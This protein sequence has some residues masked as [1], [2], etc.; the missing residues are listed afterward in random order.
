MPIMKRSHVLPAEFLLMAG[1][2]LAFVVLASP[3]SASPSCL[4]LGEYYSLARQCAV[5]RVG[6]SGSLPLLS[7][8]AALASVTVGLVALR[9]H[10][11]RLA[12]GRR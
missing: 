12:S 3:A 5:A 8:H 4:G 7:P 11:L 1:M 10:V 6:L 9:R 2:A